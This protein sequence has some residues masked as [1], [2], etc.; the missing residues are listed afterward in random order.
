MD[1]AEAIDQKLEEAFDH[2]TKAYEALMVTYGL[3][4]RP[5]AQ[6][7]DCLKQRETCLRLLGQIEA[8]RNYSSNAPPPPPQPQDAGSENVG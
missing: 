4:P 1:Q 3:V 5:S 6:A 2:A 7:R 8:M